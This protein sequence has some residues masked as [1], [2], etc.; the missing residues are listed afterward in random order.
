MHPHGIDYLQRSATLLQNV[1][2]LH[3]IS[4]AQLSRSTF[5]TDNSL[6]VTR[7]L[8]IIAIM[9][10]LCTEQYVLEAIIFLQSIK[11]YAITPKC[12]TALL[13]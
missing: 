11:S 8:T 13:L 4:V 5:R 12:K 7:A 1:M 3:I 9:A 6:N 2:A 10:P